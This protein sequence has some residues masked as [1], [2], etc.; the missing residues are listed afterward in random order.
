MVDIKIKKVT[1]LHGDRGHL[2]EGS[3]NKLKFKAHLQPEGWFP[4]MWVVYYIS[5]ISDIESIEDAERVALY[6]TE[7]KSLLDLEH[8]PPG[9]I[10]EYEIV[11]GRRDGKS[12][13]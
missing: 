11:G 12:L 5:T 2:A 6:Q 13:R 8:Y 7:V 10:D 9:R 1:K 3:I 4:K